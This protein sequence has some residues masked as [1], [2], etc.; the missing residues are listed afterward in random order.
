MATH[1]VCIALDSSAKVDAIVDGVTHMTTSKGSKYQI[2]GHFVDSGK[3][4]TTAHPC[5]ARQFM[6]TMKDCWC[7]RSIR[8]RPHH[9]S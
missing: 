8:Q 6:K 2:K 4:L 1:I 3:R 9:Y 5:A 7:F